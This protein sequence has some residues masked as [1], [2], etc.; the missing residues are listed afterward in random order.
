LKGRDDEDGTTYRFTATGIWLKLLPLAFVILVLIGRCTAVP[1]LVRDTPAVDIYDDFSRIGIDPDK[2]VMMGD[3]FSQPGD[4]FL[5]FSATGPT[6]QMLRSQA[7]F[8]SGVFTLSFLDYWCDNAAPSG[9]QLGSVVGLRLGIADNYVRIE[10][11]QVRRGEMGRSS[12]IGGYIEVNWT[13]P[14]NPSV[15]GV[16]FLPTAIT[17]GFLQIHYDGTRVTFFYRTSLAQAWTRVGP[18]LT[19]GWTAAVPMFIQALPGGTMADGYTLR[20]RLDS[21][22]ARSMPGSGQGSGGGPPGGASKAA[23]DQ[24]EGAGGSRNCP[25]MLK[26]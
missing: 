22:E 18:V 26:G 14:D 25:L 20:F 11:G 6:S 1:S 8:S 19:P 3:R 12:S 2:W 13:D 17:A 15:L 24:K 23:T 5:H 16:D 7:V 10:R 21:V 9:K 4:G